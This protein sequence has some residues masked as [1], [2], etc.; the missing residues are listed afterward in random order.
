MDFIGT[1]K[2]EWPV[3]V[4]AP[5]DVA[6]LALLAFGLAAALQEWRYKAL[7]DHLEFEKAKNT[8]LRERV[9]VSPD[10]ERNWPL[11]KRSD[12]M[13]LDDIPA[14]LRLMQWALLLNGYEPSCS[15]TDDPTEMPQG[16]YRTFKVMKEASRRG[17][18][19]GVKPGTGWKLSEFDRDEVRAYFQSVG[20]RPKWIFPE[21]RRRSILGVLR[22]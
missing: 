1:L 4:H 17:Q 5:W 9:G 20:Q 15:E 2:A 14:R 7:R 10:A 18:L 3:M 22:T 6:I 16:V 21:A 13:S 12:Y 19:K 8:E 11:A